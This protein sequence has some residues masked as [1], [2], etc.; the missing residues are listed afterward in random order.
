MLPRALNVHICYKNFQIL[1][2]KSVTLFWIISQLV[3]NSPFAARIDIF[4]ARIDI[5]EKKKR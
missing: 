4:I 5:L 3:E 2:N 1:K